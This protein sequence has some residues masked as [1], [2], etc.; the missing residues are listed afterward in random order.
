VLIVEDDISAREAGRLYLTY[1]G[2]DVATAAD[3]S[4]A[5]ESAEQHI[6][7]VLVCDWGLGAGGDGVEVAREIQTRFGVPVV[8]MTAHPMDELREA[9]ADLDVVGYLRKPISL[10][11]LAEII[12]SVTARRESANDNSF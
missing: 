5:L 7:D 12:A 8:F 9:S 4:S 1:C 10:A 3:S 11:A 2:H 6:P